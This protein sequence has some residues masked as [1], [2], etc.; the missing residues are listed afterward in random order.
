MSGR[1]K[2][3][4]RTAVDAQ[5]KQDQALELWVKGRLTYA[6]IAEHLGY[7]SKSG[8]YKA[9]KTALARHNK[10]AEEMAEHGR[11]IALARLRFLWSKATT[12]LDTEY[13]AKDLMAAFNIANRMAQL[14]GIKDP[15][16]E[17]RLTVESELD[18]EIN[19]ILDAMA[20]NG[21]DPGKLLDGTTRG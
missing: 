14:E 17:V 13:G 3:P 21:L 11:A 5:L 7:S 2:P 8:A 1:T 19:T 18:R 16:Q 12:L 10:Q 20:R 6:E 15:A 4:G 9:V